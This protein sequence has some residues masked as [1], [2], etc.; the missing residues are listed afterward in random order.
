MSGKNLGNGNYLPK[1]LDSRISRAFH[2][3]VPNGVIG[4][5]PQVYEE[6]LK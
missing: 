5:N 2:K 4:D 3:I 6:K 1:D